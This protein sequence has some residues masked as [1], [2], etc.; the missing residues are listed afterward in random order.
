MSI[1]LSLGQGTDG[2]VMLLKPT[3]NRIGITPA[4]LLLT[5][6]PSDFNRAQLFF[7]VLFLQPSLILVQGFG[8]ESFG[9]DRNSKNKDIVSFTM[10]TITILIG[11][12]SSG[13]IKNREST[14]HYNQANQ[15]S[16]DSIKRPGLLSCPSDNLINS[17]LIYGFAS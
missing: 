7:D 12:V 2:N 13:K 8:S 17:S 10:P 14:I 4:I 16:N 6:E 3:R 5:I 11:A 15:F 9:H 1:L